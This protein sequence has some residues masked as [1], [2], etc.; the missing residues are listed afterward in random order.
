MVR[1]KANKVIKKKIL[2]PKKST[3]KKQRY[4]AKRNVVRL[5]A[6]GWKIIGSDKSSSD[7]ILMEK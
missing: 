1:G 2:S 5:S 7:L 6:E 3:K 4:V